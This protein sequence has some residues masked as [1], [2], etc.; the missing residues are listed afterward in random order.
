M[1]AIDYAALAER[2]VVERFPQANT[3][4]LAGST[5]RGERTETSDVDLLLIGNE[6]FSV[7]DQSASATCESFEGEIFE[8]FAYTADGFEEWALRDL[9]QHRPVIVN[10]LLDG[11]TVR[12]APEL[13][14]TR[15]RWGA[16]RDAGPRVSVHDRDVRRYIITD[17]I[18]DLR[19]ALDRA[20]QQVIAAA[21]FE[22]MAQL[23]LLDGGRWLATGKHLPRALRSLDLARAEALI[24]PWLSFDLP[25]FIEAI[26]TELDRAGG[27]VQDG[28]VR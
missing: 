1:S 8:V 6:L 18:D 12:A 23:M 9:A 21:L 25:S 5:A 3:A 28:F 16:L 11:I 20:E 13:E 2:F 4:I 7:P 19:D 24:V 14:E 15:A 22:R 10:M 27:R 17:L 26:R